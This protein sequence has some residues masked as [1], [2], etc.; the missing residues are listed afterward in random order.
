MAEVIYRCG[1]I[2]HRIRPSHRDVHLLDGRFFLAKNADYRSLFGMDFIS[3]LGAPPEQRVL[4]TFSRR[5]LKGLLS[6]L[7]ASLE[8]QRDLIIYD[9]SYSFSSM[10]HGSK[11]GAQSGFSINKLFGL[12]SV[13][14]AGYCD[15]TLSDS[16]PTGRGRI[17]QIID[18]RVRKRIMTDDWGELRI[19]RRKADV[20]WFDLLPH[21]IAW[22][23]AQ[24]D[25]NID[26]LHG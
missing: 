4:H 22:C 13:R 10:P 18:L 8:D 6:A 25:S 23:D 2:E 17:V 21:A 24:T 1:D 14:P 20:S 11:R 15:L 5:Q 26:V 7:L 9:Y 19:Y 16:A 3:G 12:I